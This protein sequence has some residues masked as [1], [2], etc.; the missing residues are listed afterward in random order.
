MEIGGGKPGMPLQG[1]TIN[2]RAEKGFTSVYTAAVMGKT[3]LRDY[4]IQRGN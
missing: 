3:Q 2:D 4:L 1:Q